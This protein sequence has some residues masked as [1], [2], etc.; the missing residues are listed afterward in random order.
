MDYF[1][2]KMTKNQS[3]RMSPKLTPKHFLSALNVFRGQ[4]YPYD[5]VK[6]YFQKIEKIMIFGSDNWTTTYQMVKN[7]D[8]F[9]FFV[10]NFQHCIRGNFY[11]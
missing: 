5:C 4:N 8:F 1:W 9:R 3:C 6:N 10:N 11:L 2:P 7:H